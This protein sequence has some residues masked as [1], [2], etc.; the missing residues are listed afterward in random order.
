MTMRVLF[1][2]W[3]ALYKPNGPAASHL[4][5]ILARFPEEIEP[6]VA[7]PGSPPGWFPN[8]E[9]V[10]NATANE[11]RSRLHWEQRA[12]PGMLAEANAQLLHLMRPNLPLLASKRSLLSLT[13][14]DLDRAFK[15]KSVHK[16]DFVSR[17]REALGRGGL[18]RVGAILWPSDLPRPKTQHPVATLPP[19]V[20]PDFAFKPGKNGGSNEV[21]ELQLPDTYILYHGP[22]ERTDSQRL[23]AAWSWAAGP[24]G[25]YYPLVLLGL[26]QAARTQLSELVS[27]YELKE[28][29]ISLPEVPPQVIPHLY[30]GCSALFHPAPVSPWGGPVRQ[31]L[32][33]GKPVIAL[34]D[35]LTAA[36]VGSGAYLIPAED[37]RKV[38]AALITSIVE[39]EVAQSLSQSARQQAASWQSQTFKAELAA[40]YRNLV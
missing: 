18:S 7:L 37:L 21:G 25:V 40:I 13:G 16:S 27:A 32:A 19:Q 28:T 35:E 4:L 14:F 8:V 5:A 38:G 24:I 9:T 22:H 12:L 29:L 6:V 30:R 33:C 2:G 17:L 20:H 36:M 26:N 1:D 31:A 39:E 10:V 15:S 3:P 34:E 23:I 11:P